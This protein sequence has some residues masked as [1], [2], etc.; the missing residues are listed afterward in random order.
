MSRTKRVFDV[1]DII[2]RGNK[3]DF[4]ESAF[5]L[6]VNFNVNHMHATGWNVFD[7]WSFTRI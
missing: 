4:V 3:I 5:N 7:T 2:I 6:G 1:P